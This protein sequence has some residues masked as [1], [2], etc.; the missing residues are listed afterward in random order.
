MEVLSSIAAFMMITLVSVQ[1]LITLSEDSFSTMEPK[2]FLDAMMP[3]FD[4]SNTHMQ[5]GK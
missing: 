3:L 5:Q 4:A 1:V 2:M